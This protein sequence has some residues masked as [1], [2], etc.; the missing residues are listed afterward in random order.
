MCLAIPGQIK[1]IKGLQATIAYPGETRK[2]F[3]GND[4]KVKPDDY[5]MVQMGVIVKKISNRE[6][7]ISLEAWSL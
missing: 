4:I 2:A 5:V 1:E 7:K 6:A 3:L